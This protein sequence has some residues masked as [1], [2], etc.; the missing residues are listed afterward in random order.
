[1]FYMI[2]GQYYGLIYFSEAYLKLSETS[3]IELFSKSS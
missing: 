1:M 3:T 2:F